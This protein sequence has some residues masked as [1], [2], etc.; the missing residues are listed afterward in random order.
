MHVRIDHPRE[1][2]KPPGIDDFTS[3]PPYSGCAI[4]GLQRDDLSFLDADREVVDPRARDHL[5]SL[6]QQ[7]VRHRFS[8]P[9][10]SSTTTA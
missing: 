6:D 5:G 3:R 8:F 7:I 1:D 9:G 10:R 4:R 2:M